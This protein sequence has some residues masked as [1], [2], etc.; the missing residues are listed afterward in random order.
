[1]SGSPCEGSLPEGPEAE[2]LPEVSL[3][4]GTCE[5]PASAGCPDGGLGAEGCFGRAEAEGKSEGLRARSESFAELGIRR[6]KP[7]WGGI[8]PPLSARSLS[9]A[10]FAACCRQA[11]YAEPYRSDTYTAVCHAV[12]PSQISDEHIRLCASCRCMGSGVSVETMT[13]LVCLYTPKPTGPLCDAPL[14][15]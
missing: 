9:P 3:V 7:G 5:V 1:M 10:A 11:G 6:G 13:R 12:R 2:G 15:T 8:C 14:P 4:E